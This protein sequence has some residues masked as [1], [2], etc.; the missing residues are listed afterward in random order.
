[1]VHEGTEISDAHSLSKALQ[2]YPQ[3]V[4]D[5]ASFVGGKDHAATHLERSIAGLSH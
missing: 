5:V 4:F 2:Y 1:M 3:P